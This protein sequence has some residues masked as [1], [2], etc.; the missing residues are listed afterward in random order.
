M[1]LVWNFAALE[2]YFR[3]PNNGVGRDLARRAVAVESRWKELI[4]GAY[5]PPSAPGTPPHLRSG[6]LRGSISWALGEDAVSMFAVIGTDVEY[7]AYLE[8][9]TPRMAARPAAAKALEAAAL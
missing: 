8:Q 4:S 3:S 2:A 5:P 6:R 9:G 7:A 1:A